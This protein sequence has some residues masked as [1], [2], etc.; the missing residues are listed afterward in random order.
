MSYSHFDDQHDRGKLSELRNLLSGEVRMQTGKEFPIFQDRT[1]IQWGDNWKKKIV[2]SLNS[3]TFLIPIVS[4][5]FFA[6]K[7][8]REEL[9]IFAN[10]EKQL[11]RND[12]I[13]PVYY[14]DSYVRT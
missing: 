8:C 2:D 12:C 11:G 9:E 5:S 10:R 7:P 3:V 6:S 4:P 1:S 14:V 13:F